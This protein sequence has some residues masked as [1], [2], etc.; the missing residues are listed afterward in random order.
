MRLH[1]LRA[2]PLVL[3]VALLAACSPSPEG[4]PPADGAAAARA[5]A[6]AQANRE[7][8]MY[9][10]LLAQHKDE[11][12][13]PIGQEIVAK[14]PHT[15]AAAEVRKTL[16][17]TSATAKAGSEQ[18]RLKRLWSYQS[19]TESGGRQNTASIYSS[20]PRS[21][22]RRV[23]L[24]LRRH[25]DWGQSVYLFGSGAGFDCAK[26]CTVAVHFDD[27]PAQRFKA[28]LPPTGEPAIFIEDDRRFIGELGKAGRIAL[29]VTLKDNGR[30]TVVFEVGGYDPAKFPELKK[31]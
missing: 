5:A 29:D 21:T 11:F 12:A 25:S 9:R 24:I 18:R 7:L 20:E 17:D 3:T 27:A 2:L 22:A 19:G 4:E 15:P 14:Y 30:Q 23:R 1:S 13:A 26:P 31:N 16:A 10:S 6:D 8:A 28:Y